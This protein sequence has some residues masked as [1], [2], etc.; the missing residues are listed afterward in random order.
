MFQSTTPFR[1]W[2]WQHP[3]MGLLHSFHT[4]YEIARITVPSFAEALVDR[5]DRDTADARL[6][7]FGQR[8]VALAR[9]RLEV[10]G[11]ER[12]PADR[13]FVY[14]SNH[15]SHLD[16]PVLFATVPAPTLRMV[17]KTELYRLPLWRRPLT[18]A[19]FVEVDRSNRAQA[20]ASMR[21]AEDA[22]R[23]GVS[24]WLAPEGTRTRSGAL[25]PLKKGGFHL[26]RETQTPIL[27][28]AISGTRAALPSGSIFIRPDCPVRVVF[29]DPIPVADRSIEELMDEVATF[30]RANVVA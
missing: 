12:V 16:V 20:L 22:I 11:L 4:V 30:L 10:E 28:V 29:G 9:M 6:R 3:A 13:P 7:A 5:L 19:G 2:A 26:A 8:V 23:S 1:A 15:Q 24:I 14:M 25:G 17:A 21:R 18:A 27:P